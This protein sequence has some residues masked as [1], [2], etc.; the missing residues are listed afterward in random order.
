M[1][2]KRKKRL[3][4]NIISELGSVHE[5]FITLC[6]FNFFHQSSAMI[7]SFFFIVRINVFSATFAISD[8]KSRR[9]ADENERKHRRIET[10]HEEHSS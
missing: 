8:V 9:K 2:A 6:L 1:Q 3:Y 5:F 10:R 7:L 4:R